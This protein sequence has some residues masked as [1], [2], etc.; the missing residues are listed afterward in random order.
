MG[1]F[2]VTIEIGDP[3]GQG[4]ESVE[5]LVDTEATY[6]VVPASRLHALGVQPHVEAPFELADGSLRDFPLG[7]S[8][9]RWT[10]MADLTGCSSRPRK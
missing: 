9:S 8:R 5:A 4:S 2:H 7:Q 10:G 6:T 1:V 3:Q